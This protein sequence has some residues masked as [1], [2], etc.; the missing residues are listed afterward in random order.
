MV[1]YGRHSETE[2]V[3]VSYERLAIWSLLKIQS[4]P[5]GNIGDIVGRRN[6]FAYATGCGS[7]IGTKKFSSG[8]VSNN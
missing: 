8:S 6:E 7:R 2:R 5:L 1:G 4:D 3:L